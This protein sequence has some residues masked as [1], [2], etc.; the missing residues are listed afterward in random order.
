MSREEVLA[1]Y[2]ETEDNERR[3]EALL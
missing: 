1:K 2:P 3:Y